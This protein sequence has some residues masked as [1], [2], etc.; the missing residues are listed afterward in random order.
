MVNGLFDPPKRV[1][2]L[3]VPVPPEADL[4]Q[5]QIVPLSRFYNGRL[6]SLVTNEPVTPWRDQPLPRPDRFSGFS[7][8][9]KLF[10]RFFHA[11]ENI[12]PYRGKFLPD[13]LFGHY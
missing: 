10:Q 11:M 6:I 12:F 1:R 4:R 13:E 2:P 9:W 8:V 7:T 3:E 5:T